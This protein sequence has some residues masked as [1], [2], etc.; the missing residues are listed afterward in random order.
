MRLKKIYKMNLATLNNAINRSS[1]REIVFPDTMVDYKYLFIFSLLAILTFAHSDAEEAKEDNLEVDY[2]FTLIAVGPTYPNTDVCKVEVYNPWQ[3]SWSIFAEVKLKAKSG[4]TPF[5]SNGKLILFGGEIDYPEF[6][7]EVVAF[8]IASKTSSY[9]APMGQK[10]AGAGVTE[11]DGYYYV[12]GGTREDLVIYDVVERYDPASDSWAVMAPM[13]SKRYH[14]A[15][16]TW[17][18]KMYVAGGVNQ[19]Y[20]NFNSIDIYDPKSNSW[21]AGIPM[22]FSRYSFSILFHDG[23]LFAIGGND[24]PGERLDLSTE[25]WSNITITIE[26]PR[27]T[28]AIVFNKNIIISGMSDQNYELNLETNQLREMNNRKIS[29]LSAIYF[30][31][32]KTIVSLFES[33]NIKLITDYSTTILALGPSNPES[34]I[35]TVEYYHPSKDLWTVLQEIEFEILTDG[36]SAIVSHGK[37]LIFG[38]ALNFNEHLND[39]ISFELATK[40]ITNLAPMEEKKGKMGVAQIGDFIYVCGGIGDN[41]TVYNTLERYDPKADSWT[42]MAPMEIKRYYHAVDVW[43]GKMYAAGGVDDKSDYLKS[44][45]IYDPKLNQWTLGTPMEIERYKF[46]IVFI[47]GSLFALGGAWT[48]SISNQNNDGEILNLDTQKWTNISNTLEYTTWNS[49]V[50]FNNKIIIY[51]NYKN[52]YEFN[53]ETTSLSELNPNKINRTSPMLLLASMN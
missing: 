45:E 7:D 12:S 43:D 25:K 49:A 33:D 40:I 15:V 27:W 51:G 16:S 53:P 42:F 11:I 13:P 19:N 46:S 48:M 21:S 17:E 22:Q 8:D 2:P 24:V 30:L 29:R 28:G 39:V 9:L 34:N 52:N 44:L 35:C 26:D 3:D 4:Y 47:D 38:G 1:C 6:L 32:P 41:G 20:E 23:E 50:A 36:Y 5:L 18:G 31:V 10:K 37:L 14:H